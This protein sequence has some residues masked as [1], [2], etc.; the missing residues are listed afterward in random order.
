MPHVGSGKKNEVAVVVLSFVPQTVMPKML[1]CD[2][3]SIKKLIANLEADPASEA[4]VEAVQS[5]LEERCDGGRNIF[6]TA[7]SMCQPTS[8]KDSDLDNV[9]GSEPIDSIS[10]VISSRAMNLRDMMRRVAAAS[11]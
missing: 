9:A 10:S 1:Q 7:V 6:H 8:N 3:E 2:L 5:I 4:T 11:L